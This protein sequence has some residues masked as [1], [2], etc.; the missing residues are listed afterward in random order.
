MRAIVTIMARDGI[1]EFRV[2]RLLQHRSVTVRTR[3]VDEFL[4]KWY[5]WDRDEDNTWQRLADFEDPDIRAEAE[6]MEA[7]PAAAESAAAV[8]AAAA[9]AAAAES[10]AAE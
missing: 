7:R 1:G 8:A 6:Q 4:V 3:K 9:A 2:E 10:E 5:V